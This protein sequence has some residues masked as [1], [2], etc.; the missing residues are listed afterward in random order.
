MISI[1]VP[2]YNAEAYLDRCIES[3]VTQSFQDL[4]LILVNDGSTDTSPEKCRAWAHDPRVVFLSTEN[5]GVSAARNLGLQQARGTWILFLDSDDYL[6]EGCLEMLTGCI[7]PGTQEV[8]ANYTTSSAQTDAVQHQA[9]SAR[10]V[11][12]MTLDPINNRLLPDFYPV[13]PLSLPS[14]W[15]K[16]FRRDIIEA[17]HLRFRE[18]LR[19]SEDTLFHLEYLAAIAC[20]AVT[21]LPVLYYRTSTGSVTN[22]F[23]AAH[24]SNRFLYFSILMEHLD[25]DAAVQ[26]LSLLFYEICKIERFTSGPERKKLEQAATGFLTDHRELF[27][28]IQNCSLSSGTWQRKVYQAA[29]ACFQRKAYRVGYL[30]LR[31]YAI[32]LQGKTTT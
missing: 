30:L 20:V 18:E 5:K 26:I 11:R 19:L 24:L 12:K 21:N 14:C 10:S 25:P 22:T 9:V 7:L 16:L 31:F 3:V 28:R 15:G 32:A 29:A 8:L 13:Q 6:L 23:R 4:E 1:I 2:V 17:H 27:A